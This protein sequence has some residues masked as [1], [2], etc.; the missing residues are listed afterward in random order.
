MNVKRNGR[1]LGGSSG[2]VVK[3]MGW[4]PLDVFPFVSLLVSADASFCS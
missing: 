3:W 1:V 4:G 2:D